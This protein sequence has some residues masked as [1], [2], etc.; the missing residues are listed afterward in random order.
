MREDQCAGNRP[1]YKHVPATNE[2]RQKDKQEIRGEKTGTS[3]SDMNPLGRDT[4]M[5][6]KC[7]P[8]EYYGQETPPMVGFC[9]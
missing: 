2:T 7:H 9:T 1:R 4:Q 8:V 3:K 6:K 5:K